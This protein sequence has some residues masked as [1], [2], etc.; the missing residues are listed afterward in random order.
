MKKFL[1]IALALVMVCAL[2]VP[3]FAAEITGN[4]TQVV[5]SPAEVVIKTSTKRDTNN[6]G[7]IDDDDEDAANFVVT[8]PADT[9]IPW[10]TAS[11]DVG[12]TVESHLMRGQAVQV[13]VAGSGTMKT[14]PANGEVYEIAY[15][16]DGAVSF[17]AAS[18]VVYGTADEPGVKQALNVLVADDDWNRAVVEEYSDTLTYTAEVATL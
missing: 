6:D 17:K 9:V 11:T 3:A 10:G 18:P 7:K 1:S 5:G 8:V 12:Y 15:T 14:D 2:M 16:L 13:T 4:G